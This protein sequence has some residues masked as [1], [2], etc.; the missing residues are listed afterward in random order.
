[1]PVD[2]ARGAVE[3]PAMTILKNLSLPMLLWIAAFICA[4]C[5]VNEWQLEW[6]M[7]LIVILF[8]WCYAML[9]NS[10]ATGWKMPRAP[11][12]YLAG[13]FWLLVVCS[14]FWAEVKSVAFMGVCF[15]SILPLTFFIG[16]MADRQDHFKIL[17]KIAAVIFAVLSLWAIFQFFFLNAYF[18]GQA[19][20]PLADPSSLGALFSLALFCTLGWIVSDQSSR[21]RKVAVVLASLLVCGIISTVARGPVFAFIPGII[22]FCVLLWPKIKEHRKAL[23]CVVLA[24]VAFYGVTLT[25]V[26][27]RYDLGQ[28]L[29]GTVTLSGDVSNNRIKIWSSTVDMIKDRP[30]LG[31]G[32]GTYHLY[33]PEYRR[34]DDASG[35]FMAH[36][37]P[38]QFWAE[39]GVLGPLLFY[40]FVFAAGMRNYAALK[41][42]QMPTQDRVIVVTIFAALVSM[43][44]QSHVSFLHYNMSILM[45][46]GTL[47]SLW[48][49]VTSRALKEPMRRVVMPANISANA[50]R[51][52]LLLPFLMCGW[53]S[54]SIMGGEHMADRARNSLFR[55]DIVYFPREINMASKI[56]MGLN[57]RVYLFAVNVPISI[58]DFKKDTIDEKEQ[59]ELYDQVVGYMNSALGL[60]P[61]SATAYY[62]L[63]KVQSLVRP[64]VIPEGTA[65]PEE[66]YKKALHLDPLHL[67]AR[68]ALFK[69]YQGQ[70]M[71][72]KELLKFLE[73]GEEFYY[74]TTVV[75]EYYGALATLYLEERNYGKMKEVLARLAE[76]KQRSDYSLVKQ[77]TSIPQA[78]MGGSEIFEG[79]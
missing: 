41:D 58:L 12:L 71:G 65:T 49:L 75:N 39:L 79:P 51:F 10:V 72:N 27:K 14:A 53:L 17:A 50:A 52:M 2:G 47:L 70:G 16:V 19:R 44:T 42:R 74:T 22:L 28:R 37:D 6:F 13:A 3:H 62:Y 33:F 60:N 1:M 68:M 21:A 40:A 35:T 64:S 45:V 61:R 66:F 9:S 15:F 59:K 69:I 76:F 5:P 24:A 48:F 78:I 31:T 23:L 67:G 56:S 77:N 20:H 57:F 55:E 25:G 38:L 63:G 30:L 36:N 32:I 26:Q 8:A 73:E 34:A 4:I 11:V 18:Q 54:L 46:T 29:F 7:A 43:V